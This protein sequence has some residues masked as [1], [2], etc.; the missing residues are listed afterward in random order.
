MKQA[1]FPFFRLTASADG[2]RRL[3]HGSLTGGGLG[4]PWSPGTGRPSPPPIIEGVPTPDSPLGFSQAYFLATQP[5]QGTADPVEVGQQLP[6]FS[7]DGSRLP[8]GIA[9]VAGTAASASTAAPTEAPPAAAAAAPTLLLVDGAGEPGAA[10]G[11]LWQAE[12]SL[13]SPRGRRPSHAKS[14]S[15]DFGLG[16]AVQEVCNR[17]THLYASQR[18]AGQCQASHHRSTAVTLNT[19]C[20][21]Q[22]WRMTSIARIIGL[23]AADWVP[24]T[25]LQEPKHLHSPRSSGNLLSSGFQRLQ[26]FTGMRANGGRAAPGMTPDRPSSPA[27]PT[28]SSLTQASA[29]NLGATAAGQPGMQWW[30][31]DAGAAAGGGWP[32][33]ASPMPSAVMMVQRSANSVIV[34]AS[35]KVYHRCALQESFFT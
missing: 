23:Q 30:Q 20:Q 1:G 13:A 35:G 3:H 27:V 26:G 33:G 2:A 34:G 16:Q 24:P 6:S 8:G 19:S 21:Q 11:L 7:A 10:Q 31:G 18:Y 29:P 9:S 17:L 32:Q 14:C 12:A 22:R 15:V 28:Y 25:V 5:A 4:R